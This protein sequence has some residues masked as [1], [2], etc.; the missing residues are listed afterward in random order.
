MDETAAMAVPLA[1]HPKYLDCYRDPRDEPGFRADCYPL[2]RND[3]ESPSDQVSEGKTCFLA[4]YARRNACVSAISGMNPG[5]QAHPRLVGEIIFLTE[6]IDHLEDV[7]APIGFAAE[8]VMDEGMFTR[9]LLFMH[10][11][12]SAAKRAPSESS[13]SLYISI[14]QPEMPTEEEP[15]AS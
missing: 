2:V 13:F 7:Y 12:P 4:V 9:E 15:D 1:I 11:P 8:P 14:P 10:A 3:Q 5:D 6:A